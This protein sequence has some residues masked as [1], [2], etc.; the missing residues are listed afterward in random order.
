MVHLNITFPE[1]LKAKLDQE[2]KRNRTK[3][4]TFI[5]NAVRF[6]LELKHKRSQEALLKEGYLAMANEEKLLMEEFKH[7]D[8]ESFKY[9]D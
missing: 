6:Y 1:D 2:V 4:S 3:R 5:Q 9:A 8:R 7:V